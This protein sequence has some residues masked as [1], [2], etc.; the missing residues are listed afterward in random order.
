MRYSW[1]DFAIIA[2]VMLALVLY[3]YACSAKAA[4]LTKHQLWALNY[5]KQAGEPYPETLAAIIW[6]ESSLCVSKLGD[7]D[8]YGTPYAFGCGH[9]HMEAV[10]AAWQMTISKYALVHDDQLSIHISAAFLGFCLNHTHDW[11][12]AVVCYNKGKYYAQHASWDAIISNHYLLN[13]RRRIE[14]IRHL[15]AN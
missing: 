14:Q 5:A 1:K 6:Q 11:A 8:K 9:T 3:F 12:R 4:H 7:Y 13:I 10:K 2:A 15:Y